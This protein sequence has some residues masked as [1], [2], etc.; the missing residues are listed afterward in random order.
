MDKVVHWLVSDTYDDFFPNLGMN[1][2]AKSLGKAGLM[3]LRL[4]QSLASLTISTLALI[5]FVLSPN[6]AEATT[7]Y[8]NAGNSAPAS[9]YTSWLTAAT[10]I[11]DAIA[12]TVNGDT[13]LV[14][15]GIYA[16]GGTPIGGG[17]T[18]RIAVTNAI[19]VESVNGPWVTVILGAGMTNGN[20]AVRCAWLTNGASLIGF[21][22]TGGAT[23]ITGNSANL[24]GGG[25]WCASTNAYIQDCVIVSN[26]ADSNGGGVFQGTL[27]SCL[28]RGNKSSPII[29]GA[30]YAAV[31]NNCTIVSNNTIGMVFP[32]AVT[33]CIIYNNN[34]NYMVSGNAFSHCCTVPALVGT[35]NF[36]NAP[37]FFVDGVHL[38][39]GSP[40]IGAGVYAGGG[41]DIFGITYSNPPSVGCAEWP[42]APLVTTPQIQL[43]ISSNRFS[44]GN[45]AFTGAMPC[46]FN[47][48]LNGQPLVDNGYF[49][50]TQTTNLTATGVSLANAGNYQVVVSN[51]FGAV[52]SSVVTLVIHAVNASGTSPLPPYSSWAN[53]ATN[54]Q[55]AINVAAAGDIVLVTNGTY[56]YGGT[57]AVSGFLTNRVMLSNAVTVISVNGYRTTIIQ[58]S[59]D[60]TSTNGPGAVRCAWVGNGCLLKGFTL[61]DGATYA[62]GDGY[63]YGPLE[64]G[65][66]I[67]CNSTN[68]VVLDCELTNNSAVY[69]GGAAYG[70]VDNSLIVGNM[71]NYDGGGALFSTLNNC[72]VVNNLVWVPNP[73][74][75]GGGGTYSAIVRNSIVVDNYDFQ[76]EPDDDYAPNNF[77]NYAN[78]CSS[79]WP[80]PLPSGAGNT[81]AD[82]IFTD[83]FHISTLSPCYGAGSTAYSTGYD[84]V[85]LPWNNPP[86]MGCSEIVLSNLAGTLSVNCLALF[87]NLIVGHYDVLYG[88]FQGHA[89]FLSWSFGDG[90]IS[91]NLDG[92]CMHQW[93]NSG[94]YPVTFTA[95]NNDYPNG[96]STSLVVHVQSPLPAQI[97]SFVLRTNGFCFQFAS[98]TDAIYTIQYATNLTPPISWQTLQE[99]YYNTQPSIQILDPSGTNADRFYRVVTQ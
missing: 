38:A 66:G 21:T 60:P 85:G 58:G 20:S 36:T 39:N 34:Q 54:I 25:V 92:T 65:G 22:V 96:V 17:T 35:G 67:F 76:I 24:Y 98:Q 47:W 26:T 13:V 46:S 9:P 3:F 41:T 52:T 7:Y 30:I 63:D 90:P 81:N 82:P 42:S 29:Y 64:S 68:G 97:Q 89:A 95:Y 6:H 99:I 75:Y 11:Q 79:G 94:D 14:T 44:V 93:A 18:N 51:A 72:T 33:N 80:S 84:L 8:V 77:V 37:S 31:V 2:P 53:A 12:M 16:Y 73:G 48:L 19:S 88:T 43:M 71:A 32:L 28:I 74:F 45:F 27:N 83:L 70:T 10:N 49:S 91:S 56:S 69:G 1:T 5:L 87:T 15:N 55:D 62:T 4:S 23:Q 57:A 61:E 78:S 59:W 86:S 40:C 50:G